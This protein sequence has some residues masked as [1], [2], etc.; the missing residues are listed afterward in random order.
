MPSMHCAV[1]FSNEEEHGTTPTC[2]VSTCKYETIMLDGLNIWISFYLFL[3]TSE[4]AEAY[5][6]EK[7]LKWVGANN[8]RDLGILNHIGNALKIAQ[9]EARE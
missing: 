9:A 5:G 8:P 2:R 1:C 6:K 3:T 7:I 4:L